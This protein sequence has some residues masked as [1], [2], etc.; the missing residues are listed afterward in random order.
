MVGVGWGR[1]S[2]S[3]AVNVKEE[4]FSSTLLSSVLG[5]LQI[6]L[7]MDSLE[8]GKTVYLCTQHAHTQECSLKSNSQRWLEFG[9]YIPS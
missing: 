5:G 3:V 7:T 8:G 9:V 4:K 1:N 2:M 6:K